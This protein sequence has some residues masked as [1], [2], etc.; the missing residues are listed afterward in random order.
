MHAVYRRLAVIAVKCASTG[1]F[2]YSPKGDFKMNLGD[3][4]IVLG[5]VA[6]LPD[7]KKIACS[8]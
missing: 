4:L 6:N 8:P 5:D 2:T 3:V 7:L 1:E